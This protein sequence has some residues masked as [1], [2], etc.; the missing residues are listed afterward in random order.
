MRKPYKKK[1]K[2]RNRVLKIIV[3]NSTLLDEVRVLESAIDLAKKY[4]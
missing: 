2:K 3:S 4:P 1:K